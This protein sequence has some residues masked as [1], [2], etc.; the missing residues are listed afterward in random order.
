LS[1][2]IWSIFADFE[3]AYKKYWFKHKNPNQLGHDIILIR[4]RLRKKSFNH[5]E[6]ENIINRWVKVVILKYKIK[7]G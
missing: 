2:S 4:D 1:E 6:V 3:N 5:H 7:G